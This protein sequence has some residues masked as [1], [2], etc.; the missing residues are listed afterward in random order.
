MLKSINNKGFTMVELLISLGLFGLIISA[1]GFLYFTGVEGFNRSENQVKVQQNLRVAMNTLSS[2]IRKADKINIQP[3]KQKIEL[4]FSDGSLKSYEFVSSHKEI[5]LAESNSTL[6][7]YIENC[8]FQYEGE[9]NLIKI[10][11]SNQEFSGV[12][13]REYTFS[14]NAR[15]KVVN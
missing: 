13:S 9:N 14:I 15:G 2:E 8:R 5:R 1:A 4:T 3:N 11:L 7:M 12:Q 6:A 10:T